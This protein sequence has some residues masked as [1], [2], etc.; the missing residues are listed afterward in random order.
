MSMTPPPRLSRRFGASPRVYAE[1]LGGYIRSLRIRDGRPVEAIAPL[2]GLTAPQWEEI[3]AGQAP[4]F[5]EQVGL[6]SSVLFLNLAWRNYLL[7]LWAGTRRAC[8]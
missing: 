5:S 3:E 8:L 1:L 4:D 6:I 7:Q 2:A